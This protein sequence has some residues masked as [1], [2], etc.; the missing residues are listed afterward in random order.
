M[1]DEQSPQSQS[2][3]YEDKPYLPL[4][5]KALKDAGRYRVRCRRQIFEHR[6]RSMVW[7]I[8]YGVDLDRVALQGPTW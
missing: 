6:D 2:R 5:I 7:W 3:A 4:Q 8:W 1:K